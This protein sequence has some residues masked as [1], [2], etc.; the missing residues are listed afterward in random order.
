ME[1]RFGSLLK[2]DRCQIR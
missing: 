2:T 1:I